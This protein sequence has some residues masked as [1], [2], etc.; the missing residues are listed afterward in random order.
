[1]DN[2]EKLKSFFGS[3]E[4]QPT[5][6]LIINEMA[7]ATPIIS[8][9]SICDEKL[10]KST[11]KPIVCKGCDEGIIAC[12]SCV[13][14]YM[15][16]SITLLPQCMNCRTEWSDEFIAQAMD[17]TF[18]TGEYK[19]HLRE[20]VFEREMSKMPATMAA[21]E[22]QKK[23]DIIMN[24]RDEW[25]QKYEE[26][27]VQMRLISDE[28]NKCTSDIHRIS[29]ASVG[30]KAEKKEYDVKCPNPTECRGIMSRNKCGLCNLKTC[31]QCLEITGFTQAEQD[32][33]VCKP[34]NI[35]SA[36]LIKKEAKP[37]PK[38][39]IPICKIDGCDQMWCPQTGCDTA[40]SWR[41]GEIDYGRRHNPHY[42]QRQREMAEKNGQGAPAR[43]PGDILCGG[44]CGMY[45]L[46]QMYTRL[47]NCSK[48]E[49]AKT[50]RETMA[51]LHRK[52][53]H[54]TEISLP[55]AR[56][57]ARSSA[58][59][60]SH[61]VDY[62]L[63]KIN[64]EKL[65]DLAMRALTVHNKNIKLVDL[66]ELICVSG[67]ELFSHLLSCGKAG[68]EFAFEFNIKIHEFSEL[69]RYCNIEFAKISM[70]YG[71]TVP[72]INNNFDESSKKYKKS[73]ADNNYEFVNNPPKI[74]KNA[75]T[76]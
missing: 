18:I 40:F 7:S 71:V 4:Y 47:I 39:G 1:M 67:R 59:L 58:N 10:N 34:E 12:K 38:C 25:K 65:N 56:Q 44:L 17:R 24:K 19:N 31:G 8:N 68:D 53:N 28:I 73:D 16:T 27:I 72:Y 15:L 21:A 57:L 54:F 36:K 22:K 20:V 30:Q 32:V 75:V 63:D 55:Q 37:C 3:F 49:E 61:R 35:E 69:R 26:L 33:H 2:P 43:E 23:I 42:Y 51:D 9:C 62:L 45:E 66:Y 41:T 6:N 74:E 11:H 5:T 60:Q 64:K 48:A 14:R 13:K 70:T 46:R 76:I 50:I 29:L 52:I